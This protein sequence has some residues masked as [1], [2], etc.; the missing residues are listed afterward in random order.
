MGRWMGGMRRGEREEEEEAEEESLGEVVVE[1]G[2]GWGWEGRGGRWGGG[3]ELEGLGSWRCGL[4]TQVLG[5]RYG[6]VL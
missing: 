1:D 6:T 2:M 5:L 3:T 4:Q